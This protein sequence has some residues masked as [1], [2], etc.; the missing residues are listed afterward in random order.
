MIVIFF[1]RKL[2]IKIINQNKNQGFNL[3]WLL[4]FLIHKKQ[5]PERNERDKKSSLLKNNISNNEIPTY[6]SHCE[7][8]KS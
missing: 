5:T 7:C 3:L 2:S 4:L 8:K 6:L 1:E